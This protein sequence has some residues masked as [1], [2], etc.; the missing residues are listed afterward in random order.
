MLRFNISNNKANKPKNIQF[1]NKNL[2]LFRVKVPK[3]TDNISCGYYVL[4]NMIGISV[5]KEQ[6]FPIV[7]EDFTCGDHT[8]DEYKTYFSNL[9]ST[10]Y[11]LK[12]KITRK[13]TMRYSAESPEIDLRPQILTLFVRL[14]TIHRHFENKAMEID[15]MGGK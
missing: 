8:C 13:K 10:D 3:Q 5:S 15:S 1:N 7:V 4:R 6:V 14:A 2:P 9:P 12:H 11:Y